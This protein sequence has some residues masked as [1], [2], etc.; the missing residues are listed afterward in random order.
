MRFLMAV[1]PED[2]HPDPKSEFKDI[3][4]REDF[5]QNVLEGIGLAPMA[6]RLTPHTLSVINWAN[7]FNDP[8]RRQFLPMK[9]SVVNDHPM[10]ELDSLHE[11]DDSKVKGLVHRYPDKALFLGKFEIPAFQPVMVGF[12]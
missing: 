3:R 7:P 6:I 9:A 5:I 10:L 1:L 11:E 4:T 8:M 2:L 12:C